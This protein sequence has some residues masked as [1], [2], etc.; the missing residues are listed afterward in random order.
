LHHIQLRKLV[1]RPGPQ[2]GPKK[3]RAP[4]PGP[5]HHIRLRKLAR[6]RGLPLGP[7]KL[8]VRSHGRLLH[9]IRRPNRRK[10]AKNRS[11]TNEVPNKVEITGQEPF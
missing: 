7:R 2:L 10:I 5:L 11:S 6:N 9:H 1:R 8:P 3:S 4:N